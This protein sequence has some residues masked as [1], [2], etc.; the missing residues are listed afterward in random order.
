MSIHNWYQRSNLWNMYWFNKKQ[1][2]LSKCHKKNPSIVQTSLNFDLLYNIHT[3]LV[4][5]YLLLLLEFVNALIKFYQGKD[6][7][8]LNF[9]ATI[10]ICQINLFMMYIDPM[11]NYQHEHF[12]VLCHC[13]KHFNHNHLRLGYQS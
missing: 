3:L 9:V 1:Y 8:I 5:F 10:K 11:T 7:F 12:Q 4:F 2:W 13:G 6:V